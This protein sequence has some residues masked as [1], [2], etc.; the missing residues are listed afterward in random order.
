MAEIRIFKCSTCQKL[1]A[2]EIHEVYDDLNQVVAECNGCY[3]TA[4]KNLSEEVMTDK[5]IIRCS[6]CG[7]YAIAGQKCTTCQYLDTGKG[8]KMQ[9]MGGW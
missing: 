8:I 9:R 1:R 3:R 7:A 6:K 5:D 4:I 2:F